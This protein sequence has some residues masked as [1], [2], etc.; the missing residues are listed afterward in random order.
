MS[1]VVEMTNNLTVRACVSLD[2]TSILGRAITKW[3]QECQCTCQSSQ[4]E[5]K[6]NGGAYRSL[7]RQ[8]AALKPYKSTLFGL[9][10]LM[11]E[12]P[13][14]TAHVLQNHIPDWSGAAEIAS[15]P[16]LTT[17]L[18]A[19]TIWVWLESTL[20]I[21]W[22]HAFLRACFTA[23][24]QCGSV[25]MGNARD[26]CPAVWGT[27]ITLAAREIAKECDRQTLLLPPLCAIVASYAE[28]FVWYGRF[29]LH[30]RQQHFHSLLLELRIPSDRN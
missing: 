15:L 1:A 20:W 14:S 2:L 19:E 12:I 10:N 13:V 8:C 4:E 11:H 23:R 5:R 18:G 9:N 29:I 25:W 22:H 7:T 30:G 16:S 6:H 3:G 17:D 26:T 21:P 28:C 24:E 27:T